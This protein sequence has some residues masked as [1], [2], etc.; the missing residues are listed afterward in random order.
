[1]T[2]NHRS[3]LK[4][5]KKTFGILDK[6]FSSNLKFKFSKKH[7]ALYNHIDFLKSLITM[8]MGRQ[9]AETEYNS[10]LIK[11]EEDID[12]RTPSGTW[13]LNIIKQPPYEEMLLRCQLMMKHTIKMMKK[14]DMFKK[15][16]DVALDKHLVVRHDKKTNMINMIFSKVKNS[17]SRFN[18][19]A[20]LNCTLENSRACLGAVLVRRDDSL[21]DI[22]FKL[23]NMCIKNGVKIRTLTMDR[24]F[25]TVNVINVLKSL[26]IW[27]I[28]PAKRT[29]G[30][31]TA[32][33]EF[34]AGKRGAVSSHVITS[35]DKTTAEFT[36]IIKEKLDK[37]G[38]KQINLFATNVPVDAV[39]EFECGD[40][41]GVEAFVEQ[42]K[43]RW[44][45]ETGYRCIKD[46]RPKTTSRNESVRILLLFMPIFLFNAWV[47]TLYLLHGVVV[48]RSNAS[49][50]LSM[51]LRFFLL[52]THE[53][54]YRLVP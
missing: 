12:D 29:K 4:E 21:E 9:Y 40:K 34:K 47:L 51:L 25:F 49:L 2:N 13:I 6:M 19:L 52:Y 44:G 37:K 53:K 50:K 28:T 10:R 7:N 18:C 26:N 24:E 30:V 38:E 15:P 14:C 11:N 41:V 36:L 48:N 17:T 1:M 43:S 20:T 35:S 22:I 45:I 27:Y 32:I 5:T 23:V 31:K 3:Q 46:I 33:R 54:L 8:C 39:R 16:I 42:Y